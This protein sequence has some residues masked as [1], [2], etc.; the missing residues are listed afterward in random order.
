MT[1]DYY[2][3]KEK[4]LLRKQELE[5]E[6]LKARR[7]MEAARRRGSIF[8]G[9]MLAS[10]GSDPFDL[11]AA[12]LKEKHS[13]E[14]LALIEEKMADAKPVNVRPPDKKRFSGTITSPPAARKLEAFIESKGI[15]FTEFAIRANTTDRTIREFRKTGK[16]RRDIFHNIAKVMGLKPEDLLE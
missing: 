6:N 16:V 10:F 4:L 1:E 8:S 12:T 3:E 5:R 9:P 14:L 15:G 2:A 11:E 7:E 13:R